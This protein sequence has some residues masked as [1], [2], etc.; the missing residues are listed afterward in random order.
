VTTDLDLRLAGMGLDLDR[1][2]RLATFGALLLERG[3]VVN[4]SGAKSVEAVAEHLL[5]AFA[6]APYVNGPLADIGSGGGFPG[7]P[8]AIACGVPVPLI[9]SVAKKARF[10]QE[11]I[12][13]CG[14][15]GAVVNARAEDAARDPRF[16]GRFRFATA[17]A[18]GSL[19]TVLELCLPFLEVGGLALLQRGRPAA[20]EGT[21]ADEVAALLGGVLEREVALDGE[22][23]IVLV[24]KER[25]TPQAFPR[26]NGLPASRPLT[27]SGG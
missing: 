20:G 26:R 14:L 10:L 8:L 21:L 18:V 11:A 13:V 23:R 27:A 5:D 6:L 4:L 15:E 2:R 24:R 9:E 12:D 1:R 17:R 22:R 16:R 19:P 7:I 25:S 3:A